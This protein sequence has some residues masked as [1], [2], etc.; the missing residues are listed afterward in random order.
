MKLSACH[1]ALLTTL[2]LAPSAGLR[3]DDQQAPAPP[4]PPA[5]PAPP[6][7]APAAPAPPAPPAPPS[8]RKRNRRVVVES[9]EKEI[10]VDGD[11]VFISGDDDDADM[12]AD[13]EGLEELD[14]HPFTMRMHGHPGG[15]FIG[16]KPI[17]MTPE[18]RQ[19]FGAPRDAGILVGSVEPDGPA[20]KA[21]LQ[22]G[23]IVTT[24]D[25]DRI[26]STGELVRLVR[27]KKGG[28]T[29]TV[30]LLRNKA[31]RSV[32]VTVGERKASE[33]RI[34]ELPDRRVWKDWSR[35]FN[36]DLDRDGKWNWKT[37]MP[38]AAVP[39]L[40][41]RLNDIEKKLKDIEGRLPNR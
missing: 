21:G 5:A 13:V 18:L 10:V 9:P 27:H 24:V 20:A 34:G 28:E 6:T 31:S 41:E 12:I 32:K 38:P 23:D 30:E 37:P 3:A 16:V 19:H 22:V 2:L 1:A 8:A 11:R 36:R 35:D 17:E 4:A 7:V 26:E 15:G 25:G 40:E 39:D 14:G 29:I 33:M